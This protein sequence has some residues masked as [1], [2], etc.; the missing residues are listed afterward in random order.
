MASE[1]SSRA[2]GAASARRLA[3]AAG[4]LATR[5]VGRM[6]ETLPWFPGLPAAQRAW[7]GLVVQ[8]GIAAFV[9]WLRHPDASPDLTGEVFSSA[10]RELTRAV[11]LEQVVEMVRAAVDVVEGEAETLAA[12]GDESFLREAVLRYSREVAFAAAL[13]YARAAEQRGAWD[14][15]L[16]A[17][18]VDGVLRGE[19]DDALLS[20]AAALGWVSPEPVSV[21]VG[22]APDGDTDPVVDA[23]RRMAR[24]EQVELLAG[25][26]GHRLIAV[27]AATTDPTLTARR[28]AGYFGAGPVVLGPV[29]PDLSQA[30]R[31]AAEA[32][33]GQRAAAAWPDAPRPVAAAALLPERALDADPLARTALVSEVYR[34]LV[35]AGG[36]LLDTAGAYLE[37]GGSLEGTA[38]LLFVHPNTVRYRLRR[39]A[40]VTGCVP[41]DSRGAFTLRVAL[42]LGRLAGPD[43]GP[44]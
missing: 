9:E 10:P 43:G 2:R 11:T 16:E 3:R 41:T 14:A 23:L 4:P 24:R 36:A 44:G 28:L 32:L 34:P 1:R 13:V 26:Q 37:S 27:L 20:R 19:S 39:I 42:G 17:L 22:A 8:A 30:G 6:D 38:R 5:A 15:R 21:L 12:V 33:A 29:V 25:V 31:S 7:I 35:A 40:E 18:V